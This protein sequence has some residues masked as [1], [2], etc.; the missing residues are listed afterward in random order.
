[1]RIYCFGLGLKNRHY[2]NMCQFATAV[3]HIN[4]PPENIFISCFLTTT[5]T[6]RSLQRTNTKLLVGSYGTARASF[7][8]RL[9]IKHYS[10]I[11]KR[12]RGD[13]WRVYSSMGRANV[14]LLRGKYASLQ[15]K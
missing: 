15:I 8:C 5:M 9:T 1:M 7:A 10:T 11:T 2:Y 4:T 14:Q 6:T 12:G 3:H 13:L